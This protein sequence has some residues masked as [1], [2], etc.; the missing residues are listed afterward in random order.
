[1]AVGDDRR[2]A[3]LATRWPTMDRAKGS[4]PGWGHRDRLDSGGDDRH[5]EG[6]GGR[7]YRPGNYLYL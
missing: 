7:S 4:A 5:E 6:V 2:V 1:M 3:T